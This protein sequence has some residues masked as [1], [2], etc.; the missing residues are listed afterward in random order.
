[1]LTDPSID[2][3]RH[4]KER[5]HPIHRMRDP[6]HSGK[7]MVSLATVYIVW[8]SSFL[9]TKIAV[10]HL[11]I[12]LLSA[13]RFL[14]AGTVLAL[15]AHFWH[16]DAWPSRRD[17]RHVIIAG[18]FMVFAANGLNAWAIQYIPTNESALLNGTAAF[19]IAGLGVFGPRG[20]PLTR[21][22]ILGLAI[23][24]TGTALMLI[25]KGD[26]SAASLLAPL[27]VLGSCLAFSLGTLY[28]R[29]IET[30]VSSLMFMAMQLGCGGLMFLGVAFIHGDAARWT[31]NAPGLI[32]LTYLTFA[33]SCLAFTAYGWLTRNSTP[34]IIGTYSYVNPAIAAFLGWLILHETLSHLQLIGMV[35]IIVGVSILTL[36]GGSVTDPKTLGEPKA[37]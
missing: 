4:A 31:F 20:H 19:W 11:P 2:E 14:T 34:A 6:R 32:A 35:I 25:P 26:L 10:N 1:L 23:G 9:F 17:W 36:T 12:A 29:S 18:F 15:V 8:G 16:K 7:L 37:Q 33:S 5:T 3:A 30:R 21:W 27:G 24:F 28:Y 13:V 22:A